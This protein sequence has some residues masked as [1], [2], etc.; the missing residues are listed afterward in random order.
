MPAHV[1]EAF[2]DADPLVRIHKRD[3]REVVST[4]VKA[5]VRLAGRWR[6]RTSDAAELA[7]VSKRTWERMKAGT[8]SGV[9]SKDQLHR[10]SGL[11]GLYKALHLYFGDELAERWVALQN[12]GPSFGGRRPL[13]VM[14]E[15][16]LPA[17]LETRDYVDAL[18]GGV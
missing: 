5:L 16:G 10:A 15:G 18:R 9:F 3:Q 17:I 7:G 13:D 12:A 1:L 14:L 4:T 11:I 6:L 8:W 2:D